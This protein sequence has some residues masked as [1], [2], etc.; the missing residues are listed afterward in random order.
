MVFLEIYVGKKVCEFIM[1]NGF[2]FEL[3]SYFLGVF[4]GLKWFFLVGLDCVL[5]FEWFVNVK[6]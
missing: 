6:Y 4:G 2:M 1:K 3:F 5:F